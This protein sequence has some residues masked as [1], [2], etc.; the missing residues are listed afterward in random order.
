MDPW[1]QTLFW[2]AL[3]A[4]VCSILYELLYTN[5]SEGF[6]GLVSMGES[7]FWSKLVPRRGDV[8]PE[9]E[10]EGYISDARYFNDYVDIQ[11]FGVKTDFCRMVQKKGDEK[12]K[13]LACALGGTD[14]LSSIGFRGP[15]VKDGFVLGR[16]DY[17]KDINR[18]GR[19]SYCRIIKQTDGTFKS[20][21]NPVNDT[22]FLNKLVPDTDPPESIAR[23]LRFYKGCI[24]WLR[25]R[26]D[27]LDYIQ[28]L[29]V[30]SSGDAHVEENT[31]N[32][33]STEALQLNGLTQYLRIGD[34]SYLNFGSVIQ[35]RSVRAFH[36]WVRFD[37]FTNNAHVFDFGNGAGNDNVWMGILNRGNLG[38]DATQDAKHTLLCGS[39]SV[40]PDAPS[41]AQPVHEMSPQELM[42][43]TDANVEEFTCEGFAVAP[44]VKRRSRNKA[45]K[46]T[47]AKTADMCYEIWDKEQRKMRLVVRNMFTLNQWTHVVI[48]ARGTDSFRP[49]I[50][51]YKDGQ[52]VLLEPS[53]WLP[54]QSITSKN[55][56][57]R[58]N[59][60]DATSQYANKDEL[61]QGAIFDF[62][63]YVEQ[64]DAKTIQESYKWGANLLKLDTYL[65]KQ[66]Q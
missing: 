51:I 43:T 3:L 21:C 5:V 64:L 38:I 8:G 66:S 46:N 42:K 7:K 28:N 41:G 60:S 58:S 36:I 14:G 29:Y 2:L 4:L 56:I 40:V 6:E 18:E 12:Q 45:P 50:V 23:L 53:G 16:D 52:Q 31:P 9:Q 55:Y 15:S 26:D 49:D 54:Q 24:F 34:D 11:R 19:E 20:E 35:L 13:F 63:A 65:P 59:W 47:I 17:M 37:S 33:P 48:T 10:E 22:G 32:P 61:F 57:G 62:R 39:D 44:K 25:F 30:N 1:I 27:M